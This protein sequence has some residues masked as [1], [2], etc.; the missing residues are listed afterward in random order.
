MGR[1]QVLRKTVRDCKMVN[2]NGTTQKP[3][4]PAPSIGDPYEEYLDDTLGYRYEAW[5]FVTQQEIRRHDE[6]LHADESFLSSLPAAE[7]DDLQRLAV[8]LAWRR[9]GRRE[10]YLD[11]L[12][13]LTRS[14][15]EHPALD[16]SDLTTRAL[17]E[18][19]HQG[20]S[21]QARDLLTLFRQRWP[22]HKTQA[23]QLQINLA[24]LGGDREQ[25]C[26]IYEGLMADEPR[27]AMTVLDLAEDALHCGDSELAR[28]WVEDARQIAQA[29]GDTATLVDITLFIE[30]LE[31][32]SDPIAERMEPE[33]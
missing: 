21:E 32:G 31:N 23:A 18:S 27:D 9:L 13:S 8:A 22:E 29:T 33:S 5:D 10:R 3:I 15:A 16:Y 17:L 4:R 11:E 19:A 24:L 30:E 6:L 28:R 1:Q 2:A 14:T 7:L 12:L 26:T 25:A 20:A